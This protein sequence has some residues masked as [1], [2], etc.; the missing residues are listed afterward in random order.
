MASNL[1]WRHISVVKA[2][3]LAVLIIVCGYGASLTVVVQALHSLRPL[4][5][6]YEIEDSL[7]KDLSRIK[8]QD[9][10]QRRLLSYLLRDEFEG[11]TKISVERLKAFL[12]TIDLPD[13][14]LL[15]MISLTSDPKGSQIQWN[16]PTELQVLNVKA[17]LPL[18]AVKMRFDHVRLLKQRYQLI[19]GTWDNQIGPTF[20]AVHL[21]ILATTFTLLGGALFTLVQRYQKRIKLLLQGFE[22]WSASS[23]GFRFDPDQFKDELSLISTQFNTMADEVEVNRKRTLYLEKMASWQTMARKM[24]HEIKNPLTP[25]K[26]MVS[27]LVRKYDGS[28]VT[29]QKTLEDSQQIIIEEVNSLRRM[30]DSFSKFAQL[31]EPH[32]EDHDLLQLCQ[33][34]AEMQQAA[35][36]HHK[37]QCESNLS[38]AIVLIDPQLIRQVIVNITKNAAEACDDSHITI[39]IFQFPKQYQVDIVDDGPG[40]PKDILPRIFEAYF[41]TKH[42]GSTAGMGLGLA[43]CKKIVLD[44]GGELVVASQ[45]G[46]TRFTLTIPKQNFSNY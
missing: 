39:H 18:H 30:V 8:E 2:V 4:I 32:F 3:G 12:A 14:S 26:M 46:E 38:S 44:H 40:I 20:I 9:R 33:H 6:D 28:S 22:T 1:K 24:A 42:T 13:S 41:T 15:G 17:E 7:E 21:I 45:P 36:P 35:F 27:H 19:R 31:P 16:S 10:L 34:V 5:Y 37:I 11:Q 25:I 43:I 29:Y 23:P